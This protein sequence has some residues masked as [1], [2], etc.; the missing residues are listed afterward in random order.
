MFK[1]FFGIM[2]P[3]IRLTYSLPLHS[4]HLRTVLPFVTAHTF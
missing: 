1:C 3:K 2:L 4:I